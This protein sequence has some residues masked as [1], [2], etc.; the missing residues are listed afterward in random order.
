MS[1]P[2]PPISIT[3]KI[4]GEMREIFMS[5]ALLNRLTYMVG[6]MSEI[7][8]VM[9]DPTMRATLLQETLAERSPGGKLIKEIPLEDMEIALIDILALLDFISDH[10]LDF[11]MIGL[12]RLKA[13]QARYE[14]QSEAK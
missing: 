10:L 12:E 9:M 3:V 4:N 11:F 7:A 2:T 14:P 13:L 5:F 8:T 6:E 1:R